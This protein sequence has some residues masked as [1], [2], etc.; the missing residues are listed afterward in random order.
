[1]T[2]D[3]EL[4][5]GD[6]IPAVG[7]GIWK[8][9]PESTA[10]AVYTAIDVGYRHIDSACDY[11]NEIEAGE[12]IRKAIQGGIASRDVNFGDRYLVGLTLRPRLGRYA[13]GI[14]FGLVFE[15]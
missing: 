2:T 11:G 7:F 15:K 3:F 10:D 12:G 8:I 9:D 1:M 6:R 5:G 4:A 13:P 14:G